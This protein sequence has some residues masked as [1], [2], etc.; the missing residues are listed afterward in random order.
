MGDAKTEALV[1]LLQAD[2][3]PRSTFQELFAAHPLPTWLYDPVD[4]SFVDV[5]RAAIA[6]YGYSREE[7]L[8]MT[9]MDIRPPEDRSR[10]AAEIRAVVRGEV[11]VVS[12]DWRHLRR[13]GSVMRVDVWAQDYELDGR[14]L[15][16]VHVHDVTALYR[17]VDAAQRHGALFEQL[18]R[19]SPEAI[20]MLDAEDR[21]LDVNPAFEA[22]F[23]YAAE[24]IRGEPIVSLIVPPERT[25]ESAA[26]SR[27]VRNNRSLRQDTLRQ[28]RDG[29]R[30][31]VA[32]LCYPV[33]LA[34]DSV[35]A[36]AIYRDITESR[37]LVRELAYRTSH[38]LL[39]GLFNRHEFER[40]LRVSGAAMRS[41]ALIYVDIDQLRAVNDQHGFAAGDRVI[42]GVAEFL[43]SSLREHDVLARVGSDEFCA[44]LRQCGIEEAEQIAHR[45]ADDVERLDIF[46]MPL[47]LK[48]GVAALQAD[49]GDIVGAL[50]AAEA[51]CFAV[52]RSAVG[53]VHVFRDGDADVGAIREEL[54]WVTRLR[55]AVAEDRL[56]LYHQKIVPLDP[57]DGLQHSEILMRLR[58]TDGSLVLPSRFIPAAERY[59]L[60]PE[61]D[62]AVLERVFGALARGQR[63]VG[64]GDL[65]CLNLSAASVSDADFARFVEDLIR[66][67]PMRP[68][69][70]CFEITETASFTNT[71]GALDFIARVR[72]IGAKVALDD[73]GAGL[74]SFA[75]LKMLSADYLKIDGSFICDLENSALDQATVEAITKVARVKGMRTVAE[76]VG[77]DAALG[78]LRQLG[79]DYAQ[80]FHVHRP[81]PWLPAA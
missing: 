61:V 17:E 42:N 74:S 22:L 72:A 5:N 38:D 20:A 31:E 64:G 73:F 40:L 11:S 30:V 36:I 1:P 32:T 2:L 43:R 28:R 57:A 46:P 80:G 45:I 79:V 41:A 78:L 18:F 12:Q 54:S 19:N 24:G 63:S 29:V 77:S 6:A 66:R 9:L 81:E 7:F 23:Q 71:G 48:L 4:L 70:I 76:Y 47:R 51:A 75:Y 44:L 67:S 26:I 69:S 52:R 21:V 14:R 56:L 15:R 13:D 65:L 50:S 37:R 8:S 49:G 35:G 53:R 3:W 10:L 58:D 55:Q 33:R 39:T 62:R 60:M 59:A 68:D 34:D 27:A 25:E 16:L